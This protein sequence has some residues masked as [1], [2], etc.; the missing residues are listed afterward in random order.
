MAKSKLE[1][2]GLVAIGL[3]VAVGFGAPALSIVV[4]NSQIG[5]GASNQDQQ[6]INATLPS[7]TYSQDSFGLSIRE[8]AYLA[9]NKKKVFVNAIY[10]DNASEF[11]NLESLTAEFNDRVYINFIDRTESAFAASYNLSLPAALVVGDQPGVMRGRR[12]PYS[13]RTAEADRQS[14]KNAVCSAMR[15]P[16]DLAAKCF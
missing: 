2:Y 3:M 14:I 12:V 15:N 7:Q 5:G 9:V 8:Q 13:L 16:G 4:T 1:Q 6:R 10:R 11:Q